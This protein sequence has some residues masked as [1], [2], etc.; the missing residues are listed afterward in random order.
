LEFSKTHDLPPDHISTG[1][2]AEDRVL[3]EE[4]TSPVNGV[5]LKLQKEK[6]SGFLITDEE[7]EKEEEEPGLSFILK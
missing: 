2:N 3:E 5:E 1:K 7:E 4:S 6:Q